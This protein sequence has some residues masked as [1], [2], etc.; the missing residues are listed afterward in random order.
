M[1]WFGRTVR[2]LGFTSKEL[3]KNPKAMLDLDHAWETG[4][5]DAV[6]RLMKSLGRS[7]D[8]IRD[9]QAVFN[10]MRTQ[11]EDIARGLE[12]IGAEPLMT[13]AQ[14]RELGLME[15]MPHVLLAR[16]F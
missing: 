11:M 14:L 4:S 12:K 6:G 8:A 5:D 3:K 2:N 13:N 15:Y 1:D 16:F 7:D 10:E 9:Q